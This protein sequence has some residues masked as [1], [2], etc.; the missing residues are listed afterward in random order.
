MFYLPPGLKSSKLKDKL[1]V[2]KFIVH[3]WG[4][5]WLRDRVIVPARQAKQ[6]GG[7]I[8]QPP[9]AEVNIIPPV[10]DYEFGYRNRL[11]RRRSNH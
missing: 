1:S 4:D 9:R 6:A 5:S 11:A 3:D 10:R 7:P 2:A 8:R